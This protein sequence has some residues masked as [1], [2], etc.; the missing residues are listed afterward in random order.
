M[1]VYGSLCRGEKNHSYLNGSSLLSEQAYVKGRLHS[2]SSYY[3][4]LIEDKEEWTYGELYEISSSKLKRLDELEDYVEGKGDSLFVRKQTVVYLESMQTMAYVYYWPREPEGSRVPSHDWKVSQFVTL[5]PFYYF[6]YGSC[7]DDVRLK[8][9]QVNHLFEEIIGRGILHNYRLGFSYH[10]NDG[11]RA[12]IQ[13]KHSHRVE[14]VVYEIHKE[15]LDY[16]YTREGVD[17]R[18]YRPTVIELELEDGRIVRA[19][20]F[21]VVNKKEDA[22]PPFHYAEEI[23]RGGKRYLSQAYMEK[24]EHHFLHI[25]K[26]EHFNEYLKKRSQ[27]S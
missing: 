5:P 2:G 17:T 13:E 8:S 25:L 9:H 12:D 27:Q 24:L 10:L 23:H 15:A 20:T 21:T 1:F 3:P 19:L 16:L 22:V 26:V 14:G 11:S 4:Q 7:M 6:A 18:A